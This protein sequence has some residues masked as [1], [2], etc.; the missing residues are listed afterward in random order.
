MIVNNNGK[1]LTV[2]D[3]P[4]EDEF[5]KYFKKFSLYIFREW[6]TKYYSGLSC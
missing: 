5:F 4:V 3:A 6:G 1:I 2:W